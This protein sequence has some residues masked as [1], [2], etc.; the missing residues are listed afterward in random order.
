MRSDSLMV[1]T[2]L[3]YRGY[4]TYFQ[5]T[6]ACYKRQSTQNSSSLASLIELFA[7]KENKRQH[8]FGHDRTSTLRRRAPDESPIM[9]HSL[10]LP[11]I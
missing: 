4:K 9:S 11:Q 3:K 6:T 1:L 10:S 8:H 7:Y 5:W 2:Y